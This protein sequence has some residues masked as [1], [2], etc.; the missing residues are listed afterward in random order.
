MNSQNSIF[1]KIAIVF[2]FFLFAMAIIGPIIAYY[3]R[4]ASSAI[5]SLIYVI[6]I[7]LAGFIL[8]R[9]SD[10]S[11]SVI[12]NY[13]SKIHFSHLL[14]LNILLFIISI[15][16]LTSSSTRPITYF[17]LLS[18]MAGVTFAQIFCKRST[19]TDYIIIFEI[20]ALSLNLVWGI[21]L[22]YPL[23]FGFTDTLGHLQYID[24]IVKTNHIW[25]I[26]FDYQNFPLYHIFNAIGVEITGLS[27]RNALF[28]L[29]GIEWQVGILFSYLIFKKLTNSSRFA[30][31][32]CLLFAMS[33][34]LIFYGS[35]AISRS[36]AFVVFLCWLFLILYRTKLK[37]VFLS[38]VALST[39]ILIHHVTVLL[40]IPLLVV[41]YVCQYIFSHQ[42]E[43]KIHVSSIILL[44]VC[45]F[46]YLVYVAYIFMS[47]S[48]PAFFNR[49]FSYEIATGTVT[50]SENQ[51]EFLIGL[52]YYSFVLLFSLIGI[53]SILKNSSLQNEKTNY[54][55][56][57]LASLFF[58]LIYVSS[59]ANL[60]PQSRFA[61]SYRLPLLVS[62]F[63]ILVMA[64][65][66]TS[67]MNLIIKIKG[68]VVQSLFLPFLTTG[69]II[70]S[71]FFSTV[72]GSNA[73]DYPYLA[74]PSNT[75]S[76]YFTSAELSSFSFVNQNANVSLTLYGDYETVRDNYDLGAF[77]SIKELMN[78]DL[79]YI[80]NGY[81]II[82]MG[83]LRRKGG[84]TL[85]LN[86]AT[87]QTQ[88]YYLDTL[89]PQ[90]ILT[91][92]ISNEDKIYHDGD[93][94]VYLK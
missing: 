54:S 74:Y 17:I 76:E 85:S 90:E 71:T 91:R 44:C 36:L 55:G 33:T 34:E 6:P 22:K 56:F 7:V 61:W 4:G 60:I 8:L 47:S 41:V 77:V 70:A 93:V 75:G 78:K 13:F 21:S 51:F 50:T 2:P 67:L 18:L 79:N 62:P 19:W 68:N 35:Y 24:T 80:N 81:I 38:F 52:I 43:N 94:E 73:T 84:L 63:I 16:V 15:I 69:L 31:I 58:L 57:A 64:F 14:L 37:Y 26:G 45:F 12:P 1:K 9:K 27:I 42:N 20:I 82:R 32:A 3:T 48:M 25:D 53:G 29:M 5:H 59:V 92:V 66:V 87:D 65:G 88:R 39:L 86:G 49:I 28:I 83:E 40:I 72:C 46:S 11:V 30:L 23:Y 10:N 89:Q